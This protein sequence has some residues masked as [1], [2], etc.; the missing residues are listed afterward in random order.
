MKI[1]RIGAT[2]TIGQKVRERLADNHEVIPVGH[3]DGVYR[4]HIADNG[5]IEKL[6][7]QVGEVDAVIST[8]GAAAFSARAELTDEQF[9]LGWD[10]KLMGQINLLRVGQAKV[11][12]GGVALLTS[13]ILAQE[14][15]PGVS[16]SE[17]YLRRLS[18][19][20]PR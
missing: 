16:G 20:L 18:N 4:V 2:G 8:T 17:T 15:I 19:I 13:G 9:D 10:N 7:E 1:L 5:S 3:R 14:P 11:R 12:K 6:F